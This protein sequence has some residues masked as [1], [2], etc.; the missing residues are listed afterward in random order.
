M[1]RALTQDGKELA[2]RVQDVAERSRAL[3]DVAE[4][5]SARLRVEGDALGEQAIALSKEVK[6]LLKAVSRASEKED[7]DH[8]D[9]EQLE[10]VLMRARSMVYEGDVG[11]LLPHKRNGWFL[12]LLLGHV[13]VRSV[14]RDARFKVKE[15]YNSYRDRTAMYFL[16]APLLLLG[17]KWGFQIECLPGYLVHIYQ[18]WLLVFY[19][20][21]ALRENILRINGSDIRPWWIYH[22][23]LAILM[24]MVSLT[25]GIEG[26][27]CRKKQ[28]GV[29]LFLWWAVV[30][31]V[32]MLLQNRYQRRRLYARIALGK[33]GRMDV[34]WGETAGM[35]GQLLL[36]YP[37]LFVL[38]AFQAYIGAQLL[39]STLHEPFEWQ[40]PTCGS[41]L[42]IMAA[43]NFSNTV[44]TLVT[45]MRIKAKMKQQGRHMLRSISGNRKSAFQGP[46]PLTKG[47]PSPTET[48]GVADGE[49]KDK[50]S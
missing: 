30:Q 16:A 48:P 32:A 9:A 29:S 50:A 2:Q 33:A 42:I 36:L 37:L 5:F 1:R 26:P 49:Q 6:D 34:V 10:E 41:L 44:A 15:E 11:A 4:K 39:K 45:K 31:G 14:R 3:Q 17:C 35:K 21:L 28:A 19:T 22:H 27:S 18:A 43:G 13:N 47:G 24:A 38:Q 8:D 46:S 7:L 25:W 40:V 23:Y 20:S 12:G